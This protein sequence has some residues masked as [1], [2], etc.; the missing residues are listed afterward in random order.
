MVVEFSIAV[1]MQD[2]SIAF[3]A[4]TRAF[5]VIGDGHMSIVTGIYQLWCKRGSIHEVRGRELSDFTESWE[6]VGGF[7]NCG[8]CL[9]WARDP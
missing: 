9:P 6:D 7:Y 1:R 8:A 2:Q 5:V 3:G 4:N